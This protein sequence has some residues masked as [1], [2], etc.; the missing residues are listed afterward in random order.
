MFQTLIDAQEL[1][2]LIGQPNLVII[3]C[4]FALTDTESGKAEYQA[5][6]LP[7]AHYAHLDRDLSGEIIPGKTG[8]HPLPEIKTFA[9]KCSQWGINADTQVV[10]YDHG[11]GGIAAR[12][13][14]LLRWLGHE[15]VAVLNGGWAHWQKL[16]YPVTAEITPAMPSVF[17]P[18]RQ[19]G[20]IIDLN[21]LA[22]VYQS[23]SCLV[24]DSRTADR[25]RGENE[26]IDPV[27]GH[28]PGA[29]S[30]PFPDNLGPDGLFLDK[31]TLAARFDQRLQ[32][33]DLKQTVFYCGSGVT[34]CHNLLALHYIG[35][36]EAKLFPGSWSEW[37][38]ATHLPVALGA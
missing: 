29:I 30:A 15:K 28:I 5:T 31:A 12:L 1:K 25:Y 11:N 36:T 10:A 14:F 34:A 7:G 4:R 27:A 18:N 24:V 19:E 16:Q 37:I 13:W 8:R 20:W 22:Q 26:T 32:G 3:D 2:P 6:H 38:T 35:R 33:H 17:T 9:D 21:T 23:A